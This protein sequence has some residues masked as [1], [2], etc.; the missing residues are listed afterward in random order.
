MT[1][2]PP[3]AKS[4][5]IFDLFGSISEVIGEFKGKNILDV[6][7]KLRRESQIRSV[8]SSCAIEGN[9]LSES[10][11]SDILDNKIVVGPKRDITEVQNALA[12]YGAKENLDFKNLKDLLK[13]HKILMKDL[14]DEAGQFRKGG[15]GIREGQK[16]IYVA[17]PA[18]RVQSLMEDLFLW[19]RTDKSEN[20]IVK[21]AVFHCEFET[22][23]PF[24]DGN[25]RMG[26]FW[27]HLMLVEYHPIFRSVPVETMVHRHQKDYYKALMTSQRSGDCT[28]FVEFSL[29]TIVEALKIVVSEIDIK[30]SQIHR[31]Q[32]FAQT[33]KGKLFA[34]SD[35]MKFF[36]GVSTATASNDLRVGVEKKYF[37]KSGDKRT[38]KYKVSS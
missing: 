14:L 31:I 1:Y 35:Y 2:K 30:D 5:V 7:P 6:N 23:H 19:I 27:Q 11:V 17:P 4:D 12:L 8:T 34:R 32:S 21:S 28:P 33:F 10:V 16:I 29:F 36:K 22:I 20:L 37:K 38:T 25:G 26:R 9:R 3:Y 15:V 24:A 18:S 13:S